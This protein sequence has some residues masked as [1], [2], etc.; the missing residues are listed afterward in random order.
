MVK[1]PEQPSGHTLQAFMAPGALPLIVCTTCGSF[2]ESLPR[3]LAGKCS[4]KCSANAKDQLE[5]LFNEGRHPKHERDKGGTHFVYQRIEIGDVE[6]DQVI[7][8]F[9]EPIGRRLTWRRPRRPPP[10][11]PG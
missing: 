1:L 7:L 5:K 8:D 2:A 10:P 4:G 6:V 11:P 3:G 9:V